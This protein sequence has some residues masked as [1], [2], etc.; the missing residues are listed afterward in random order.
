MIVHYTDHAAKDMENLP[1]KD[2]QR[3]LDVV[4]RF[5]ASG[6]GDVRALGGQWRG[7]FRL[8]SGIWRVVFR[9]EDGIVVIRVLHR[10]EA[11]R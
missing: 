3:V 10:R 11:Y 7:R 5:A 9:M 8:R 4:N 1:L 2:R 6:V